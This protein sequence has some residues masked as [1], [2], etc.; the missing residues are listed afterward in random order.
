MVSFFN[1]FSFFDVFVC[2]MTQLHNWT[3]LIGINTKFVKN[4]FIFLYIKIHNCQKSNVLTTI[5]VKL[6]NF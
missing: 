2:E 4:A 6:I 1:L 5:R 3:L